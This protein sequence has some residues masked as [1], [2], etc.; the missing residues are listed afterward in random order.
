M[1]VEEWVIV[2]WTIAHF[3]CHAFDGSFPWQVL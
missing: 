1:N 3:Y 2:N